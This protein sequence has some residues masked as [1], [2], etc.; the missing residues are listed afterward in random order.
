[1]Y[2]EWRGNV[3]TDRTLIFHDE[4]Q[5]FISDSDLICMSDSA[6]VSWHF[7]NGTALAFF[8]SGSDEDFQQIQASTVSHLLRNKQ[9]SE[10]SNN[11]LNSGLWTC[12]SNN[13]SVIVGIYHRGGETS[14]W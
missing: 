8:V 3:T 12:Q 6:G 2:I 13:D 4:V 9:V 10:L 11:A 5:R 7:P 1:M 14:C